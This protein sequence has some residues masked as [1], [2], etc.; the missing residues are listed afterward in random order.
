M[1]KI[2]QIKCDFCGKLLPKEKHKD[3]FGHEYENYIRGNLKN[4]FAHTKI[5]LEKFGIDC[6]EECAKKLDEN[7]LNFKIDALYQSVNL[8]DI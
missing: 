1:S 6:C 4:I 2:I 5:E 3:V 7:A 8:Y